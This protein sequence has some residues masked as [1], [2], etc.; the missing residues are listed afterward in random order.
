MVRKATDNSLQWKIP[1]LHNKI[2]ALNN[3]PNPWDKGVS[4]NNTNTYPSREVFDIQ[5]LYDINHTT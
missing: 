2:L 5:L 4:N 1:Y 3:I